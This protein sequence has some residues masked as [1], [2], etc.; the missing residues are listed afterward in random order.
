ER[1]RPPGPPLPPNVGGGPPAPGGG[2]PPFP[3]CGRPPLPR[4]GPPPRGP[5]FDPFALKSSSARR[6]WFT[7]SKPIGL[8]TIAIKSIAAACCV[9]LICFKL[10]PPRGTNPVGKFDQRLRCSSSSNE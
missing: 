7:F 1:G 3:N 9:A 2:G 4:G 5:L 8:R 10:I 6:I